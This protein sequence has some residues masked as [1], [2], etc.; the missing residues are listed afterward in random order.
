MTN[1]HR[2]A[3]VGAALVGAALVAPACT[4][5]PD[6]EPPA[7]ITPAEPV[8][9]RLTAA[10]YTNT[11]RDLL[12]DD[13]VL[14]TAL[15]PDVVERGL[16]SLGASIATISPWGV[17]QY[18]AASL[19][20][21]DQVLSSGTGRARLVPCTATAMIDDACAAAFVADF[22]KKAWRRPV[23]SEELDAL[24]ALARD[25]AT[26]LGD[27][28][29]GLELAFAAILQAPDFLFRVELGEPDPAR[30]G[31]LRYTSWE[32]ASRLAYF[33]WNT[34]PD[35]ELLAAAERGDLVTD[36]GL[37]TEVDRLLASPRAREG[38]RGFFTELFELKR[39]DHLSKDPTI[40]THF[41]TELGPAARE[42]TLRDLE[43]LVFEDDGDYRD[44]FTSQDTFVDRRLAA[45]YDVR[46]TAR[47]GFGRVHLPASSGRR[48]LL[49]Q[50][51]ILALHAHPVSSSATKRGLFVRRTL[52]CTE[53]P[54]P[55]VDVNTA[56]PEPSG[57]TVTL[58]D[59]VAEHLT[60]PSCSGCHLIMDPIGLGLESFDGL[61]RFRTK[62]NGATI[63]A[64]G[65]LAGKTWTTAWELAEVVRDHPSIG[66]CLVR[67]LYR[68]ATG[69]VETDG[70]KATL[71]QLSRK[72][73]QSGYRVKSLIAELATS[74]GF[75]LA[76][77]PQ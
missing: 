23:T 11:I 25:G 1:F 5:T 3:L 16:A 70:E 7:P 63:D 2:R 39:L 14:P 44:I 31:E 15:E 71:E 68:F 13:V 8:L 72:F 51:S 30:P 36:A 26:T 29:E 20:L 55:P 41:T 4:S 28:H 21:A 35:A 12:G 52:M 77:V 24:V 66:P 49:G 34:T 53:I 40:L 33:L 56:L 27:F 42:Q 54:P 76:K 17:E 45:I 69:N 65:E 47:D 19:D 38:V 10:Q 67:N 60:N 22:G 62:E 37:R 6:A 73:E 9:H 46:A 32:M 48:G 61:G 43:Q 50:V 59:R 74:P 64:S 18:E 75:R 58:R 57:N